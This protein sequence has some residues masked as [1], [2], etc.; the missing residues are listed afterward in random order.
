M[1]L[2]V[3]GPVASVFSPDLDTISLLV[4]QTFLDTC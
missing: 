3:G 1:G 4:Q 2:M